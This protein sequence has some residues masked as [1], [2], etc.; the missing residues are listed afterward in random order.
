MSPTRWPSLADQYA[1]AQLVYRD[2]G[3]RVVDDWLSEQTARV[4]DPEFAAQFREV[5][6]PGIT[7]GEF[8]HRLVGSSRGALLGGIRFRGRD[9]GRPFVEVVAHDFE[10][11]DDLRDCVRSEW[12]AFAPGAL[13]LYATPG[14]LTGAGVVTDLTVHAARCRDMAAPDG[15]VELTRFDV[16]DEAVQLVARAYGRLATTDPALRRNIFPADAEAVTAWCADGRAH[17]VRAGGRTVGLLAVAPGRVNWL[18]GDEILEEAI[19]P[20]YA[21]RRY[22]ASAQTC[23]ARLVG[24]RDRL[25]L[26]TIDRLNTA[27]RHTALRAG[28]PAVL[29]AVFLALGDGEEGRRVP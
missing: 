14:R 7:P 5:R 20:E 21:G 15:R 4:D 24:D 19:E 13:R 3:H 11:L 16:G 8:A 12:A 29:E 17:A 26:G 22:A 23:W 1:L 28:R 25:L 6:L 2:G 9:I 27:S 18:E 10:D